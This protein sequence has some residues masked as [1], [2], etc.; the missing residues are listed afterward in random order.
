MHGTIN[1]SLV[2]SSK[3]RIAHSA[4]WRKLAREILLLMDFIS[5]SQETSGVLSEIDSGCTSDI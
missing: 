3:K 2:E 1:F 4:T 5:T